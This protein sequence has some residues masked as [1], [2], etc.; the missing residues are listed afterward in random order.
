MMG[1]KLLGFA[2]LCSGGLYLL[3][4]GIREVY[5]DKVR[6]NNR[7]LSRFKG[8]LLG[9]V[10]PDREGREHMQLQLMRL[11]MGES[12]EEYYS[13]VLAKV[14][15]LGFGALAVSFLSPVLGCVMLVATIL[16]WYASMD[17]LPQLVRRRNEEIMAELPRFMRTFAYGMQYEK[18]ILAMLETY[19][20]VAGDALRGDLKLL[21][22]SM[23][24][25]NYEEALRQFDKAISIPQLSRFVS[26]LISIHRGEDQTSVLLDITDEI[27]AM[28]RERLRGQM[29]KVP[30]KI[31]ALS[32]PVVIG[33]L[34][35]YLFVIGSSFIESM[36]ILF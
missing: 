12:V 9:L 26:A 33:I 11:G 32:I 2:L 5:L 17:R 27:T 29:I 7:G 19:C 8:A 6:L 30:D 22:Q 35:L 13:S 36:N 4:I 24:N 15:L 34:A 25:S 16:Q 20:D 28:E 31:Q 23:G 10:L 3:A 21:I 1:I 14:G 18:D